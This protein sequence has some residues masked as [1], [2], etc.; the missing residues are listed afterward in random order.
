MN[1]E[2]RESFRVRK[3][4]CLEVCYRRLAMDALFTGISYAN[5][6]NVHSILYSNRRE[7]K[8]VLNFKLFM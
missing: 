6:Q 4:I 3:R 7:G 8:S 2:E 1:Y 5:W